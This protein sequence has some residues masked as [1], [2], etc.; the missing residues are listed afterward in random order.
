VTTQQPLSK[1]HYIFSEIFHRLFMDVFIKRK[2]MAS[3]LK[4]KTKTSSRPK[5]HPRVLGYLLNPL[6]IYEQ[7]S[8]GGKAIPGQL[9]STFMIY[10]RELANHCGIP[11]EDVVPVYAGNGEPAPDYCLAVAT[12]FSHKPRATSPDA[13]SKAKEFLGTTEE[14]KWY[15][16]FCE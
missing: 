1:Y 15:R 12:N 11:F 6:A 14:P 9:F 16:L 8:R 10:R 3:P 7:A 5:R 2:S 4:S 13:I